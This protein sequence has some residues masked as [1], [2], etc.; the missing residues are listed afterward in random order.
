MKKRKVILPIS[1]DDEGKVGKE[2]LVQ[3]II[4]P[5]SW[6]SQQRIVT[7][8]PNIVSKQLGEALCQWTIPCGELPAG[9]EV[10]F[11]TDCR[12]MGSELIPMLV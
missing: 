5:L 6:T 11:S 8:P 4:G 3:G 1:R 10:Q 12:P 7:I 9:M 2:S